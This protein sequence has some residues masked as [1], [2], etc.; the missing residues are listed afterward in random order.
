MPGF[1]P[2][3]PGL[4]RTGHTT[5]FASARTRPARATA[6][7][8]ARPGPRVWTSPPAPPWHR[9]CR[10]LFH[11]PRSEAARA[12]PPGAWPHKQPRVPPGLPRASRHRRGLAPRVVGSRPPVGSPAQRAQN[13]RRP[14]RHG[15]PDAPAE[16]PRPG[17]AAARKKQSGPPGRAGVAAK[18]S[19]PA[20]PRRLRAG[21]RQKAQSDGHRQER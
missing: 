5:P 21:P 14:R 2:R 11:L 3:G 13:G 10:L 17:A 1:A 12:P 19:W 15:S 20:L 6:H 8:P 18:N 16:G 7:V 4:A 9:Q